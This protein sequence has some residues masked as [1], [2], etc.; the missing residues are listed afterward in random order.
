M[1]ENK[2]IDKTEAFKLAN[3][4]EGLDFPADKPKIMEYKSETVRAR[5]G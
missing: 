5:P 3:L 2:P 4:L 1:T